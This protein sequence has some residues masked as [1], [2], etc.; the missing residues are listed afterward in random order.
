MSIIT[1]A[2]TSRSQYVAQMIS[3]TEL[4]GLGSYTLQH[5][6][7]YE[8][9]SQNW[10]QLAVDMQPLCIRYDNLQQFNTRTRLAYPFGD[11]PCMIVL[12]YLPF[13]PTP[14]QLFLDCPFRP[15]GASHQPLPIWRST[16]GSEAESFLRSSPSKRTN[17]YQSWYQRSFC[18]DINPVSARC[19][20]TG[21]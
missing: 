5:K 8:S 7:L 3:P 12:L 15:L 11:S 14:L 21:A 13:G 6:S 20:I 4:R 18:Q 2:K 16:W 19:T 10:F 17:C 9:K 1:N